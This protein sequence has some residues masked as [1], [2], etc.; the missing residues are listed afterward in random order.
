MDQTS[1]SQFELKSRDD[2][3]MSQGIKNY[4]PNKPETKAYLTLYS[5]HVFTAE[6]MT[7]T[8]YEWKSHFATMLIYMEAKHRQFL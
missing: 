2:D 4:M 6:A 7:P 3:S 1:C 8:T 5:L